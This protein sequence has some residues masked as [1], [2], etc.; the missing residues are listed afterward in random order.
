VLAAGA[1]TGLAGGLQYA[2]AAVAGR[3]ADALAFQLHVGT[4]L[5]WLLYLTAL[6]VAVL[7]LR[8]DPG[9]RPAGVAPSVP[10]TAPAS[11][12]APSAV[13]LV[14]VALPAAVLTAVVLG[15][16]VP[17][18]YAPPV[19]PFGA[20]A[21]SPSSPSSPTQST[22]DAPISGGPA[23]T[24]GGV[25]QSPSPTAPTAG[26]QLTPTQ[27]RAAAQAVR[28]A[29]PK[30]WVTQESGGGSESRIE[31]AAC[32]PLARD[33]YLEVLA[34]GMKASAEA[35]YSS[36]H[37]RLGIVSTTIDVSVTSYAEPVPGS[38]FASADA[39]RAACRQFTGTPDGGS[40]VRFVVSAKPAPV[41]GEQS[42][43]VDYAMTLGSGQN[44][45]T[46]TSAFVLV[47][48]GHNLVTIYVSAVMEP[49]DERLFRAA[50]TAAVRALDSP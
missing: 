41:L 20:T 13:L 18:S 36:P 47:R 11:R 49:L 45:I 10:M 50:L 37:G 22:S 40:A 21:G 26:R 19:T 16:G 31:P 44:K 28:S 25:T 12:V 35:R 29:L 1:A 7:L 33:A 5:V 39:A 17:G 34:P 30:A 46:G 2:H 14:R 32:R 4:P 38:V 24:T 3:A 15:P 8:P 6:S 23:A 48:V 27:V 43:R 42:W 9:F